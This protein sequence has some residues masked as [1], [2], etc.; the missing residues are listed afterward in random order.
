MIS[1]E[2]AQISASFSTK[3]AELQGLENKHTSLS[4]LWNGDAQFWG[5]HSP[6]L[7]PIVGGLKEDTYNFEGQQYQ[8]PRHG[9]ARDREFE[10]HKIGDEE[11]LFLLKEDEES[12][13]VY[14]FKFQLG[15]HYRL[16]GNTLSCSYEV[17]NTGNKTLWFS[18][19]G[20][21][22]FSLPLKSSLNYNDY[23]LKFNRDSQLNVHQVNNNLIDDKT[24]ILHL[25]SAGKLP[26]N[27]ELFYGDALVMKDL[28]SNKI[29]LKCDKDSHGLDFHFEGFPY[30]G[31]WAAKDADFVCLEPWC[32]IADGIHHNQQLIDK[33]GIVSLAPGK[34]WSRNWEVTCF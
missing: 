34:E 14:P 19:G 23:Y 21:P 15:L 25:T 11:L 13:K 29:S 10:A 3:G 17:L 32:G 9:F 8:L 7:F 4:Y 24:E 1:L 31:I 27:H 28:K 16:S 5:K 20:H 6:V 26:L 22:A 18:V 30:F 33:E 12:L 2:N